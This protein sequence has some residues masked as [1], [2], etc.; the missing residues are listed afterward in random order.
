MA[1]MTREQI[2]ELKKS[3]AEALAKYR[4][5][6]YKHPKLRQL[7]FELTLKC[8]EACFHCGSNCGATRPDGLPA[9]VYKSVLDEVKENFDISPMMLCITGGEPLLRED[10][11]DILGSP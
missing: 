3:H 5:E 11:F 9:E 2:T 1:G 6:L 10:F 8:N 4:E 7:F